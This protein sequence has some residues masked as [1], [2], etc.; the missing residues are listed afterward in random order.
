MAETHIHLQPLTKSIINS[1]SGV[2]L[3]NATS[4]SS[5]SWAVEPCQV[6]LERNWDVFKNVNDPCM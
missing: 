4:S 5:G 2:P 6:L 1:F 3:V